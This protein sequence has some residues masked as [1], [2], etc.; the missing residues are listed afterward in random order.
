MSYTSANFE[1]F[2][3]DYLVCT[4]MARRRSVAS[5][6]RSVASLPGP[7]NLMR[8]LWRE[9]SY[10]YNGR[11]IGRLVSKHHKIFGNQNT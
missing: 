11:S 4:E 6:E 1:G 3:G 5:I 10:K 2:S 8:I 7:C 9:Q